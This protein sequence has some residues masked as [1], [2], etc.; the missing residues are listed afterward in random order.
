MFEFDK[1]DVAFILFLLALTVFL[2]ASVLEEREEER[3]KERENLAPE[4]EIEVSCEGP[5]GWVTYRSN[6]RKAING[7]GGWY[8]TT[9]SGEYIRATNCI[10]QYPQEWR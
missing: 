7:R 1:K 8:I 10:T 3:E 2:G 9:T 4:R 5:Q 6:P